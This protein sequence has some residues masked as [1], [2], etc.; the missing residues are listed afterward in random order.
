L[1]LSYTLFPYTTLFRSASVSKGRGGGG[2]GRVSDVR[3]GT[4][5]G[6]WV[7]AASVLGSAVAALDA[8]V[9]NVALPA[10]RRDLGGGLTGLQWI[11]DRK[12]TRL[13]S[14]HRTIS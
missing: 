11:I 1:P 13:N 7:L 5:T 12:S 9:V 6:R 3:L 4:P 10:I 14:S 8:T 2:R